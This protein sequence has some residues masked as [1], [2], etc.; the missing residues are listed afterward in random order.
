MKIRSIKFRISVTFTL[1]LFLFAMIIIVFNYKNSMDNSYKL[2]KNIIEQT[3]KN[4]G[5]KTKNYL[6]KNSVSLA[7]ITK[8]NKSN[9]ILEKKE[10]NIL[11]MRENL[12]EDPSI[13]AI[14]LADNFGNLLQLR[15]EPTIAIREIKSIHNKRVNFLDVKDNNFNTLEFS[16]MITHYDPREKFW[17]QKAEKNIVHISKPYLFESTGKEGITLYFG[18]YDDFEKKIAVGAIDI[19]LA[20]LVEF[21]NEQGKYINGEIYIF[22]SNHDLII[23]SNANATE[24][25]KIAQNTT[26][27]II[28][29]NGKKYLYE[30]ADFNVGNEKWSVVTTIDEKIILGEAE[31]T[32]Y[33]TVI[34]SF[35]VLILFIFITIKISDMITKPIV[36]LSKDI[37]TLKSLKTD[38]NLDN[39]SKILEIYNAQNSLI[40]LRSGIDSFKKYMPSDLVKILI[41]KKQEAVIGGVEK[42]LV[43][44]F[45]DI[46]SFTTISEQLSPQMLTHQLSEYF[47]LM[48][49]IISKYEGTIDKYIG[50]AVMSFWGAPTDVN[51]PAEKAVQCAIEIQ[52]E[53][54]KLNDDWE[55]STVARFDTRVGVHIGKTLVGNIGSKKR[56]NYTIIGDTVNVASRLEGINKNYGTSIIISEDVYNIVNQKFSCKYVDEI[57]LKGKTKAT[58]IYTIK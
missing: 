50:D 5:E 12:L 58:K 10:E 6:F 13:S 48:E 23:S 25:T 42:E 22:D 53:L 31:K 39:N 52:Q 26:S 2:A 7:I 15:R 17:F 41:D 3:T 24:I 54:K 14:Y 49:R 19:T 28:T 1:M 11:N 44:M 33:I 43:V 38:V 29:I 47:D 8:N 56:M 9:S 36:K 27:D 16:T 18:N 35:I 46:K 57:E 34:V 55:D 20:T 30:K 40:S 4:V 45:T 37:D 51:N 32:L 21:L